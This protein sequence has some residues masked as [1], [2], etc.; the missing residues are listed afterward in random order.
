MIS[1][2]ISRL[3]IKL[4]NYYIYIFKYLSQTVLILKIYKFEINL[5]IK[6]YE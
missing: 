6:K 1:A 3:D 4:L 2:L 5:K